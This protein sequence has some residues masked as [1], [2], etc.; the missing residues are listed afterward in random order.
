MFSAKRTSTADDVR[1]VL[2]TALIAALEDQKEKKKPRKGFT[3][4]RALATGAVLYTAGRAGSKLLTDRVQSGSDGRTDEDEDERYE[5]EEYEE[6][7]YEEEQEAEVDEEEPEAEVD[8]EEPEA[9][10]DEDEE[11]EDEDF[12]E[13][14]YEEPE[15]EGDEEEY[16]EEEDEEYEEEQDDVPERPSRSR[17]PVGRS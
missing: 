4:M 2:L 1:K 11:Y 13:E 12:E 7:E 6:E 16:S 9:E 10:V 8:E 17:S 5:D 3:G 15:A 14:E